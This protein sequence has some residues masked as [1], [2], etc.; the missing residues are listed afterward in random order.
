MTTAVLAIAGAASACPCGLGTPAAGFTQV[1]GNSFGSGSVNGTTIALNQRITGG[2]IAWYLN[3]MPENN[4]LSQSPLPPSNNYSNS[5]PARSSG[6]GGACKSV[7]ARENA[8]KR[9]WS[10]ANGKGAGS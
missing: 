7:Q 1:N 6:C 3:G 5:G 9:A 8:A 10:A 4:L 2:I